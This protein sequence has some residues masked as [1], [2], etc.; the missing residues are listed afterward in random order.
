MSKEK[1]LPKYKSHKEVWA[2]RIKEIVVNPNGSRDLFFEEEGYN[3]LNVG[4]DYV[5]RLN[6]SAGGYYLKYKD[7]SE[8]FRG[9]EAF[10]EGNTL[11]EEAPKDDLYAEFLDKEQ[12]KEDKANIRLA[13]IA[14]A[15]HLKTHHQGEERKTDIVELANKLATFVLGEESL[16]D[17]LKNETV[18]KSKGWQVS[19]T[20]GVAWKERVVEERDQLNEKIDKLK[21]F[22]SCDDGETLQAVQEDLLTTQL[23]A[24][25]AYS[26]TLEIRIKSFK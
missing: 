19:K 23:F 10:E 13:C 3:P 26:N 7:G 1:E 17:K 9:A 4:E 25:Q 15:I 18:F 5:R 14:H 20:N 24:M 2:L 21:A 16:M 12:A 6:P 11:I 22:L 8:S